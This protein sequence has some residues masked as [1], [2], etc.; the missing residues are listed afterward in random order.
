MPTLK[1]GESVA[2]KEYF[3][4][5]KF[6][7]ITL[8][9]TDPNQGQKGKKIIFFLLCIAYIANRVAHIEPSIAFNLIPTST[10]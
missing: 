8:V 10:S 3:K 5:K 4:Q 1:I 7:N 2:C 9:Q 6:H